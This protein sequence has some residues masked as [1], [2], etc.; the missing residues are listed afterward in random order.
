MPTFVSGNKVKF[1]NILPVQELKN[2]GK[3]G[4]LVLRLAIKKRKNPLFKKLSTQV[5]TDKNISKC[6]QMSEN[7][8]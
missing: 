4:F 5:K 7:Y 3:S 1:C 6:H 2:G 8:I